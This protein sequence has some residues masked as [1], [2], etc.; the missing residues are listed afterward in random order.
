MKANTRSDEIERPG[1]TGPKTQSV[2]ETMDAKAEIIPVGMEPERLDGPQKAGNSRQSQP[3]PDAADGAHGRAFS[4]KSRR[5]VIRNPDGFYKYKNALEES[6]VFREITMRTLRRAEIN[7][8]LAIHGCQHRGRAQIGQKRIAELAGIKGKR[9]VVD[10][11]RNLRKKGLLEVIVKG[12]YRPNGAEQ[13]GLSSVYR[14]YPRPEPRLVELAQAEERVEPDRIE[15]KE[16]S[17]FQKRS[18]K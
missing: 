17:V 14:V 10:A 9:H 8:W 7:V 2:T 16:T 18:P 12:R 5:P 13:H 1:T 6:R 15:S 4:N 3:Q 11:I